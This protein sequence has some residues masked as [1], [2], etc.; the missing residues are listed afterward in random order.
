MT[1]LIE[2]NQ[3][4]SNDENPSPETMLK[5]R[6]GHILVVKGE[7]CYRRE[8]I[9]GR[10]LGAGP[11]VGHP[12]L[13]KQPLCAQS[14]WQTHRSGREL[15]RVALPTVQRQHELSREG[16]PPYSLCPYGGV[17]WIS[18][19]HST[20]QGNG[21]SS[22]TVREKRGGP[23]ITV[24]REKQNKIYIYA[25]VQIVVPRLWSSLACF[26]LQR[27]LAASH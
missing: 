1:L 21:S 12:F 10:T 9:M 16:V 7:R 18:L 25:R 22:W 13:V 5:A 8:V 27:N 4:A 6:T 20:R 11:S 17:H 2:S 23:R 24:K 3:H 15:G 14:L 19:M 26:R